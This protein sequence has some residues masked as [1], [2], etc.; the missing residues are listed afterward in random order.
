MKSSQFSQQPWYRTVKIIKYC[1]QC[2]VSFRPKR[3]SV[4]A[5]LGRCWNCR[6]KFL[7]EYQK[8]HTWHTWSP[9]KKQRVLERHYPVWLEWV[10]RNLERRRAIALASYHRRKIP[11]IRPKKY[12]K[13]KVAD[14]S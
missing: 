14:V 8:T 11:K 2:G 7:K 5:Q 3:G 1:K 6:G 13:H 12:K 4:G 9:E 10:S